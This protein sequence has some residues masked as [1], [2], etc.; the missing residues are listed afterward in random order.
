[1][2]VVWGAEQRALTL[3]DDQAAGTAQSL[4]STALTH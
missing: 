4:H 3:N 1:M 2:S